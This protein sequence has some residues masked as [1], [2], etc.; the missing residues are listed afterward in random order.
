MSKQQDKA[1]LPLSELQAKLTKWVL[2]NNRIMRRTLK[3]KAKSKKKLEIKPM[4][5]V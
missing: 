3:K 5:R 2:L 4:M 1:F